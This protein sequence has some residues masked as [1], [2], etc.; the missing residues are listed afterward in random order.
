MSDD[1]MAAVASLIDIKAIRSR[2]KERK[3]DIFS[4]LTR[5][6]DYLKLLEDHSNLI[7]EELTQIW[8]RLFGNS[9][10]VLLAVGG[11]GRGLLFPASD[12]DLLILVPDQLTDDEKSS[13]ETFVGLLWDIGLDVGHSVRTLSECQK[14]AKEDV[15]IQT[16]L[17]ETRLLAGPTEHYI[18][19]T[20][21][22]T[23]ALNAS[24]FCD[25]KLGERRHRHSRYNDSFQN[26]EPNLKE[27]PGGLRDLQTII[28]IAK[29]AQL[30]SS[31]LELREQKIITASEQKQLEKHERALIQ[32]RTLLHLVS[33]RKEDRLLFDFQKSLA[34]ELGFR[35]TKAKVATEQ[36]MQIVFKAAKSV[37]LLTGIVLQHLKE[38]IHQRSEATP[39][40]IDDDF[41]IRDGI[42]ETRTINLFRKKPET[43]FQFFSVV[44]NTK[45]VKEISARTLRDLWHGKNLIDDAFRNNSVNKERFLGFFQKQVGLTHTLRLMN[46]Y[47]VI[48]R[49]LPEFGQICGQLQHDLF[50]VYTV[51]EHILMVVRNLRRFAVP[52][53]AHEYPL[54]SKLITSFKKPELL[55][56]AGLYHDIAKGR[57]GDHSKL[58]MTDAALFC[59]KHGLNKRDT[60]LVVWLVEQHLFMST[61]AQKQDISDPA[62]VQRFL[63]NVKTQR[64]LDALYLL[65]VA[66]IRGT[67]PKVWN[68]FKAKLLE[69]LYLLSC[70]Q[71]GNDRINTR[72]IIENKKRESEIRLLSYAIPED[73]HQKF[74]KMLDDSYFIRH[75]ENEIVWH[76]RVLNYRFNNKAPI[77]KA[78]LSPIGDGLQIMTYGP[79]EPMVIA[80][81]CSYFDRSQFTVVEAKVFTTTHHYYL[82]TFQILTNER[83]DIHYR[84]MVRQLEYELPETLRTQTLPDAVSG[85]IS[86][87]IKYFPIKPIVDIRIDEHNK[88]HYLNITCAD[89]PGLLFTISRILGDRA[90]N[91]HSA[92]INTLG[93]RVEDTLLISGEHLNSPKQSLQ[94]QKDLTKALV[95]TS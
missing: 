22:M 78:R 69:D 25:A 92:R 30:G 29:A 80:K 33:N 45:E 71:L 10:S 35:S 82:N 63:K 87:R 77:V 3:G 47:E 14:E 38:L 6:S 85:R 66:D 79:D 1:E 76:A 16:T 95:V 64:R 50:H 9:K 75:D 18:R 21:E 34:D 11:Y 93:D 91:I 73:A 40:I 51:D 59:G 43:I 90:I 68:A 53:M 84:D 36:L 52:E 56:I 4:D 74:W 37:N 2:I 28:W 89:R 24:E 41:Q 46:Q 20:Q 88:F 70:K 5:R 60:D 26:L 39:H 48:G 42:L 72:D 13:I 57:G 32:I 58:G 31:W 44:Q 8:D 54:C 81:L 19:F 86:R 49:Y 7:D 83:T 61:V 65:T 55:Y 23:S 62:V 67:S 12:V 17:M 94:L 27:S 15:T